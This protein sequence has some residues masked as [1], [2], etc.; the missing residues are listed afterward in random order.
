M[1]T[2]EVGEALGGLKRITPTGTCVLVEGVLEQTP[3]GTKQV[4]HRPPPPPPL[5][6]PSG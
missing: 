3:E 5:L 1:V 2:K 6:P 4:R